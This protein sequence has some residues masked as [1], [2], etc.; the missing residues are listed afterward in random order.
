MVP[1]GPFEMTNRTELLKLAKE[2]L[3]K[4]FKLPLVGTSIETA[5]TDKACDLMF[6]HFSDEVLAVITSAADGL[7]AD[8]IEVIRGNIVTYVN[9]IVDVPL[10]PE[11]AEKLIFGKAVDAVLEW[12]QHGKAI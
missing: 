11:S 8:E 7:E 3:R 2:S 10:M 12:L 5:I 4:E 1:K 9:R 6:P